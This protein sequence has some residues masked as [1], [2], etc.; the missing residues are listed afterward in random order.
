MI[1]TSADHAPTPSAT[2]IRLRRST[3][4]R[5]VE[6]RER[7]LAAYVR[8]NHRVEG[9]ADGLTLDAVVTRLLDQHQR[10]GERRRR[11]LAGCRKRRAP[12]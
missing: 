5:L 12:R 2:S 4:G 7:L 10:H 9:M 11:Q 1:S 6:L 3:H 8:A